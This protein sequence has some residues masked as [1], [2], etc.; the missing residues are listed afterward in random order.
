MLKILSSK[1]IHELDRHTIEEEGIASI[2]L[3]ERACK[4]FTS[5]F[6]I[7]YRP[8]KK[9]GI[10]CGVGNNGGDGL[11]IA[12]LLA[13]EG[14]QI[15]VMVVSQAAKPTSDFEI[16]RKRLPSQIPCRD[17]IE[18][19]ET[20]L[21]SGIDILIDALFGS[22]LSRPLEGAMAR[23]VSMMNGMDAI[24]I[25]VDIPSGLIMDRPSEGVIFKAHRTVSF[26]LPKLAFFIPSNA[27]YVGEWSL[28][29]IGLSASFL[30]NQPCQH[31]LVTESDMSKLLI[32][33]KRFSHKGNFGHALLIAGS[34]GMMGAC[35]LS[36]KAA[37]RAGVGLLTVHI[38]K[39]EKSILPIAL[40]EAMTEYDDH[41]T[42]FSG[43]SSPEKYS[44]IGI[45]PGLGKKKETL[46]GISKLLET[47][48][49][50]MVLDADA[51]NLMA[52]NT[53]LWHLIPP[54]SILTPHP[55]EFERLV[56]AWKDDFERLEKLK[57]LSAQLKSVIIL[58]GAFS[59]IASPD[60]KI[61]FN[62]TGN[63]GMA[64]SGSGDVLTGILTAM[65]AQGYTSVDTSLISVYIH[66]LA[67]DLAARELGMISLIASD[68]V[69]FVPK[70]FLQIKKGI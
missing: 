64:T 60:G 47:Y 35:V 61:F 44:A 27:P 17:W 62:P 55:K 45:G 19:E 57:K 10:V 26:Q 54:G 41:E 37:V 49:R 50:P 68:I 38:P 8:G 16:N 22:G 29:D 32:P 12:R 6:A 25:A 43:I 11:G 53:H 65:L 1:E 67:G 9:I 51:L 36:A 5:W 48:Q 13:L 39:S 7:R 70:A 40:P 14:F 15:Q 3:M 24:K 4:A 66:G 34:S 23:V 56:G 2:D 18:S 63:P 30:S 59:S 52:E 69:N 58:K 33:R 31:L 20:Q 28:V 42:C 21:F 46:Q